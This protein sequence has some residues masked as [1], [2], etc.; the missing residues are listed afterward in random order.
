M[1]FAK[2]YRAVFSKVIKTSATVNPSSLADAVGETVSVTVP[3]ARF[4]DFVRVAAPYTLAGITVTAYVSAADQ[5]QIRVQNESG[6]V[7]DLAS[8]TWNIVVEGF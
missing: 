1:S 5:V 4:G 2:Q 3:G 6:G 7:L 8:G